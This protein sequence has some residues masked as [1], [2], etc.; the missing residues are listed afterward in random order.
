[1]GGDGG[2]Q[3]TQA[4]LNKRTLWDWHGRSKRWRGDGM[5][6]MTKQDLLLPVGAAHGGCSVRRER[7]APPSAAGGG[8]GGWPTWGLA[9]SAENEETSST[10]CAVL[11]SCFLKRRWL[12]AVG[13]SG[14]ITQRPLHTT[15]RASKRANRPP[16]CSVRKRYPSISEEIGSG[17]LCFFPNF[18]EWGWRR[19]SLMLLRLAMHAW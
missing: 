9:F 16:I 10:H 5:G 14:A 1:M 8:G 4:F 18:P 6:G 19:M 13:L 12:A 7:H 11:D 17:K 2:G 15:T 3:W